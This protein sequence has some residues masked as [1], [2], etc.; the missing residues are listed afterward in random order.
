MATDCCGRPTAALP[1]AQAVPSVEFTA[2]TA[3]GLS[4]TPPDASAKPSGTSC[5]RLGLSLGAALTRARV[6]VRTGVDDN[7]SDVI[8]V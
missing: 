2:S 4:K 6:A 8:A 1:R 3:D 7:L 5:V